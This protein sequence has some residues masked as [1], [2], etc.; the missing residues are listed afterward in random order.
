MM[1]KLIAVTALF[2]A[3]GGFFAIPAAKALET[4]QRGSQNESRTLVG[5]VMNAQ[6]AP[7]AKAI[8]YLKNTKTLAIKTYIAEG[9]GSFRF[10]G[11][12]P[13]VDY[14]VYA[15][16]EGAH[17]DTKTLSGFD[18]RKEVNMTLKIHSK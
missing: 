15:E 2:L 1:K 6:N 13:N 8:V 17:S 3:A 10:S 12:A 7:Q 5:H 9:D 11:I 14:E 18:S 16:H 4:E